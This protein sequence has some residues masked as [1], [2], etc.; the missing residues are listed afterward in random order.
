MTSANIE[1]DARFASQF[2]KPMLNVL[3][4]GKTRDV[5]QLLRPKQIVSLGSAPS[6][7][8]N[9]G[10][11]SVG[12]HADLVAA[13]GVFERQQE[14]DTLLRRFW[15][16]RL[17]VLCSLRANSGNESHDKERLSSFEK[18]CAET[19]FSIGWRYLNAGAAI[20]LLVPANQDATGVT[21]VGYDSPSDTVDVLRPRRP[22]LLVAGF[23]A[24]SNCGDEALLQVI[25]EQF[26]PR[27][28]IIISLDEHGATD[29][30]W[31]LYPYDRCQR[32]HQGNLADPARTCRGM[33]VG[34]GGLPL[35]FVADQVYAARSA[36]VPI[37]LAGT[38]LPASRIHSDNLADRACREY[39]DLFDFVALRSS[40]AVNQAHHIGKRV[41]YGADWA[42]RLPNDES[43]DVRPDPKRALVVLREY[44]MAAVSYHY[45][46][47][48]T[49]LIEILRRDG[50]AP[51]LLPFCIEDDRFANMLGLDLIAPT[52]RHWWNARRVKQLIASS[53]LIVSV[54]R[55][56]PV[57]F[58]A[59][60]RT[61]VIQLCPP[62]AE[63]IDPRTFPKIASMSDE[64]GVDYLPTVDSVDDHI[65]G[66]L[67]RPS[68]QRQLTAAQA[69]LNEMIIQLQNLFER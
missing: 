2:V 40:T 60:T 14:W 27:F 24:R 34:G 30:Y 43:E 15:S 32:I 55:L 50:F 47:E 5:L 62:L 9:N 20:Y 16:L 63:G 53:G 13:F 58:A 11:N 26:S 68:G 67:C 61:P 23:W 38:D 49:R 10:F 52:E 22:A 46:K 37:A 33:I 35:G 3:D 44:P 12:G 18:L 39:L 21:T 19:G 4:A 59:T 66:N 69:R 64:L 31:D 45:V 36:G 1:T 57:I 28:D 65:R 54:G 25:Y 56:H 41:T 8:E 17:P 42:L 7:D 29:G 48:V 6:S 51:T